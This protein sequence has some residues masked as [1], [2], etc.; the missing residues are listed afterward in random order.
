VKIKSSIL[1]GR[2]RWK[3]KFKS[4]FFTHVSEFTRKL[5]TTILQKV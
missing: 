1:V 2:W 5:S 4:F 3:L